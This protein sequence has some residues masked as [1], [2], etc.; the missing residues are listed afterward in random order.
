MIKLDMYLEYLYVF[1]IIFLYQI[2]FYLSY[3]IFFFF[4]FLSIY[5][6]QTN[7]KMFS[8]CLTRCKQSI[9]NMNYTKNKQIKK[10]IKHFFKY[11]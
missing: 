5:D 4:F 1:N 6:F 9:T 10:Q 2:L 11:E 7:R 8:V 3:L